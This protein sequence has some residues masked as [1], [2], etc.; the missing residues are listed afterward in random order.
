[1]SNHWTGEYVKEAD[2]RPIDG[3]VIIGFNDG[4]N[5]DKVF[6]PIDI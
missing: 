1:L 3:G 5:D 6:S 4:F 2:N